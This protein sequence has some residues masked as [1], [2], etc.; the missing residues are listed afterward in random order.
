MAHLTG[1]P[2]KAPGDVLLM[3]RGYCQLGRQKL[4]SRNWEWKDGWPYVVDG[5]YPKSTG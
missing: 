5:N 2:T 4:P 3:D 1:R